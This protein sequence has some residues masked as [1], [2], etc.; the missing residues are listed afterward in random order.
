MT[1][2]GITY[3]RILNAICKEHKF[4]NSA[5]Q[6]IVMRYGGQSAVQQTVTDCTA[7]RRGYVA[8]ICGMFDACLKQLL[9]LYG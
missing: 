7:A 1:F 5:V 4:E 8:A 6:T 3:V 9:K 2:S